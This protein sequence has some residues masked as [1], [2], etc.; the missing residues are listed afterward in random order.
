MNVLE[1]LFL[2]LGEKNW[3]PFFLQE[4]R[5]PARFDSSSRPT[6][7]TR[8]GQTS[9][10]PTRPALAWLEHERPPY[11]RWLD[12]G[13][14]SNIGFSLKEVF[15]RE[16]HNVN[17]KEEENKV[18]S[19]QGLGD[20]TLSKDIEMT[21]GID[22]NIEDLDEGKQEY[23]LYDGLLETDKFLME[24]KSFDGLQSYEEEDV[25]ALVGDAPLSYTELLHTG[26]SKRV[27]A[28]KDLSSLD[29]VPK[30][31][32][33]ISCVKKASRK[34]KM[35]EKMKSLCELDHSRKTSS[36]K[37]KVACKR[38]NDAKNGGDEILNVH[39]YNE[40][41][42][43]TI[44]LVYM[45]KKSVHD[46]YFSL[47]A[48]EEGRQDMKHVEGLVEK[49]NVSG[50]LPCYVIGR[51]IQVEVRQCR[52]QLP[53]PCWNQPI[54]AVVGH[55]ETGEPL[56]VCYL[57]GMLPKLERMVSVRSSSRRFLHLAKAWK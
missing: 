18:L 43:E 4:N 2:N 41:D 16:E 40:Q 34:R 14:L 37:E 38:V 24:M 53:N 17:L 10:R 29:E 23:T 9:S 7:R 12:L 6:L 15:S 22:V 35:T 49:P 33:E 13:A 51:Q 54:Q 48:F 28:N 55:I 3:R 36:S 45:Q 8:K 52:R 19:Q 46:M 11:C 31:D 5:T 50:Q 56:Q 42:M 27:Q 20:I 32:E 1:G 47:C 21:Q 30:R 39:S 44:V 25:D 57:R 26:Q